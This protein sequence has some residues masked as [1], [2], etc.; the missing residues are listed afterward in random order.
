MQRTDLPMLDAYSPISWISTSNDGA[1]TLSAVA[2]LLFKLVAM[3]ISK[4]S[5]QVIMAIPA[6]RFRIMW[7]AATRIRD[8]SESRAKSFLTICSQVVMAILM[9]LSTTGW[10]RS[11]TARSIACR[12]HCFSCGWAWNSGICRGLGKVREW[13]TLESHLLYTPA[14][15]EWLIVIACAVLSCSPCSYYSIW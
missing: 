2:K 13:S 11:C 15:S 3:L 4:G 1:L 12:T 8:S 7:W 14:F 10:T 6:V 9:D 5:L